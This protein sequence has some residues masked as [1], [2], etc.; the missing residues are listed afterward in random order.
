MKK[1]YEIIPYGRQSISEA[2]I[3]SVVDVLRS[4]YLTQGPVV[5]SF[6]EAVATYC[7]AKHAVAFNSATSGLHIACLALNLG[8]GDYLWTSPITFVA[9]ANCGLY[10]GAS[11]DFVDIDA[12]TFNLCP[13]ALEQ[14]LIQAK[15]IGKLP[16]VVVVVH[17]CG[18][19]CNMVAIYELSKVYGFKIIEDASHAIGATYRQEQVGN[20]KYS[21]VTIFSFHPVKIIT[22]AEGGMAV[23]N[24]DAVAAR[25]QR[26]RSHGISNIHA[27]IQARPDD[28]IW[29]YQQLSLG[30][31]CRMT[32]LQAAL[33]I[34]QLNMI[35]EFIKRRHAIAN[36]YDEA[37]QGL[38]LKTPYQLPETRSSYHLYPIQIDIAKSGKRQK[39]IYKAMHQA[40]IQVNLHYIPVYRHPYFESLGFKKGYC[41]NAEDYF[42]KTISIPIYASMTE[43]QKS[44]VVEELGRALL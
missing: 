32:E 31:N 28:E 27:E 24:D 10:C 25:M 42:K 15:Q 33:G 5:P 30:F 16:K 9:S 22:T 40:G 7:N 29:N 1:E 26:L 37:L 36:Y 4:N 6:E 8:P 18:Q 38:P 34:S 3:K 41:S 17:M 39:T 11:V 23:T 13:N 2:D 43:E 12:E 21:D 44:R 19:P 20:C 14:K 35:D